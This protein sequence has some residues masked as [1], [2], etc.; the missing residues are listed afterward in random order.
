[1]TYLIGKMTVDHFL[2]RKII[3]DDFVDK[4]FLHK[5]STLMTFQ[6]KKNI[7]YDF[8]KKKLLFM[9]FIIV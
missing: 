5:G 7:V 3:D 6:T 9:T 1:M 4:F 8:S 2:I